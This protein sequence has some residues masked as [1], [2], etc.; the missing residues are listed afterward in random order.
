MADFARFLPLSNRPRDDESDVTSDRRA[1]L[2]DVIAQAALL[3]AP[4]AERDELAASFVE[5]ARLRK[6]AEGVED[7]AAL[8]TAVRTGPKR[9]I[10]SLADGVR[11]LL[12]LAEEVGAEPVLNDIVTGSVAL[13]G[14]T[15]GPFDRRAVLSGHTIRAV[16]ADW[17]FG[18]GPELRGTA[19][20]IVAF[21]LGVSDVAPVSSRR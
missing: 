18:S 17:A 3:S 9:G 1:A 20:G 13:W 8:A 7:L 10:R 21:V 12:L 4:S 15:S 2:A 16:D 14:T 19:L 6:D 11:A 5:R